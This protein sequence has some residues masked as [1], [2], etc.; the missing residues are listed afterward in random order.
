MSRL[1]SLV[2]LAHMCDVLISIRCITLVDALLV[3][4]EV[5]GLSFKSI[6]LQCSIDNRRRAV[7]RTG[8][9]T[10]DPDSDFGCVELSCKTLRLCPSVGH[11]NIC[12]A[13]MVIYF[14]CKAQMNRVS[15][16][17]RLRLIP[18]SEKL[19]GNSRVG[20]CLL[21]FC[22]EICQCCLKSFGTGV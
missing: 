10:I 1:R 9:R 22:L 12:P 18:Q 3:Y 2:D 4:S 17:F 20:D 11:G 8:F 6:V 21:I 13:G 15:Q 14:L 5:T 16:G 7:W 19:K